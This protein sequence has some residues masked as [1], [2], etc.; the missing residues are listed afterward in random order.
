MISGPAGIFGLAPVFLAAYLLI[1]LISPAVCQAMGRAGMILLAL[2]PAA[3]TA[4]AAVQIPAVLNGESR[5]TQMQ[6]VPSISLAID[7]RLDALAMVMTLVIAGIGTLVLLYSARY[8]PDK[9]EGL[10]RYSGSLIAFAGAMLGL[11]WADNLILLVV[12]WELTGILSYLLIAH[13]TGKRSSR[14][15]ASQALMVTTAGG[16]VMLIGVVMLGVTA[17]TF[18]LS[19]ILANPPSGPLITTSIVLMIVG[20]ISKSAIIPFQFWLP[21]AMAAP[22]PASAYLHAAN[23]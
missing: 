3:T 1:A 15:A 22:T 11:V 9:D 18:T 4:W 2:L 7:L 13:R 6:W 8:F 21:G 16:L 14:A 5:T 12:F 23:R 20:G 17:G 10:G 19:A